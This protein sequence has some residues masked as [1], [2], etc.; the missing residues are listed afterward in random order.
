MTAERF[1]SPGE[2]WDWG[3]VGGT[4]LMWE[5]VRLEE[6]KDSFYGWGKGTGEERW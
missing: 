3:E 6:G 5:F 2:E 4:C 1:P